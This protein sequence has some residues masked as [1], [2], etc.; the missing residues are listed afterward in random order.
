MAEKKKLFQILFF[1]ILLFRAC[2]H[3][4]VCVCVC[5]CLFV[6]LCVWLLAFFKILV[7]YELYTNN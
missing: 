4:C 1:M 6:C 7:G 2:A 5:V 3:V